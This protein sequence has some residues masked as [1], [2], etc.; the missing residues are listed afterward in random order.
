MYWVRLLGGAA[1]ALAITT[2][3]LVVM[4]LLIKQEE[5]DIKSSEMRKI[6][7][8]QMGSTDIDVNVDVRKPEKPE[9][10]DKE[11]PPVQENLTMRDAAVNTQTVNLT[12]S[13]KG[14]L[15]LGGAKLSASDG[16][17]LPIVKVPPEYPRRALA[18]NVEGHCVVG[19]TVTRTGSVRDPYVIECSST[20][21]ENTSL[22]A[23][24]KFKYK[25]RIEDGEPVEVPGV[26]NMFTYKLAN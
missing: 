14:E 21:F 8:I 13:F 5:L 4:Q 18:R 6:A 15:A 24:L 25:P 9:T 20:L 7:D 2:L 19:F 17:Y 16:E 11:P 12:P 26:K 3:L 1:L 23:V 10:P 22:Q